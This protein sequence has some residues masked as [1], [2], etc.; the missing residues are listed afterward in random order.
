MLFEKPQADITDS[1]D[2]EFS[3]SDRT[4]APPGWSGWRALFMLELPLYRSVEISVSGSA[5]NDAE[6]RSITGTK[7]TPT[8]QSGL[9][10]WTRRYSCRWKANSARN[11]QNAW[12]YA[13]I[14]VD[15]KVV[16][17]VVCATFEYSVPCRAP[18]INTS[19]RRL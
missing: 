10:R 19:S 16:L 14:D 11:E 6:P 7:P 15:T 12:L 1:S 5:S 8:L 9:Y 13:A 18:S 4:R 2:M 3:D 17:R